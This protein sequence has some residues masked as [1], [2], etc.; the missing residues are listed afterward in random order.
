MKARGPKNTPD[1]SAI[2]THA[3]EAARLLKTL[4][5]ENRLQVLC[6]LAAGE[7]PV[8]EINKLLDLTQS[9]LSQ[10]LAVLREEKLVRTR[11]QA[12]SI[13]Y[14]LAPGPAATVMKA[15]HDIYCSPATPRSRNKAGT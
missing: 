4:A 11:R 12:Q 3:G 7:R 8:G 1:L 15:L 6:L 14:S 2:Q 10:H 5:N 13:H 9:A